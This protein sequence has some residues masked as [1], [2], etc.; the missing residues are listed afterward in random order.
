MGIDALMRFM[1]V[2]AELFRSIYFHRTVR[3]I[4]LA[5]ADLF[6]ESSEWIFAGNPLD[7]LDR[8][9]EQSDLVLVAS[10]KG[11]IGKLLERDDEHTAIAVMPIP[12]TGLGRAINDRLRRAAAG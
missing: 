8:Y 1:T 5:L 10:G 12:E 7:A 3:A 2:R 9:A 11:E 6:R 4:D